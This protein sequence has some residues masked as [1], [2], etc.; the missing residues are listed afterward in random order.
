VKKNETILFEQYKIYA[1]LYQHEDNLTWTKLQRLLVLSAALFTVYG[2]IFSHSTTSPIMLVCITVFGLFS[3]IALF[4]SIA[5]GVTFIT[6]RKRNTL[7]IEGELAEAGGMK[8]LEKDENNLEDIYQKNSLLKVSRIVKTR[9]VLLF[10]P[11]ILTSAW[12]FL[13]LFTLKGV[14]K[15]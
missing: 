1:Q 7:E 2:A 12:F 8:I 3:S 14:L 10:I 5:N 11:L 13:F 15:N 9:Q 6:L 4:I